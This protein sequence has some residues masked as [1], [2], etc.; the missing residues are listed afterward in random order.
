MQKN[1]VGSLFYITHTNQFKKGL[2]TNRRPETTKLE[3]NI[4]KKPLDNGLSDVFCTPEATKA[5]I[6]K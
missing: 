5:V 2:K 4:G 3:E 1:K 6:N